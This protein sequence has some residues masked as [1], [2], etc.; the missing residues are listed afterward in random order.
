M[1]PAVGALLFPNT[2]GKQFLAADASSIKPSPEPERPAIDDTPVGTDGGD[3]DMPWRAVGVVAQLDP[4]PLADFILSVRFRA[5]APAKLSKRQLFARKYNQSE[6]RPIGWALA[7]KRFD[8]SIRPELFINDKSG[9]GEWYTFDTVAVEPGRWLQLFL[10]R[11]KD[12]ATG[13]MIKSE[14]DSQLRSLGGYDTSHI[15]LSD[16]PAELLLAP[17]LLDSPYFKGEIAEIALIRP[18]ELPKSDSKV[19]KLL[20][21]YST[22]PDETFTGAE[23]KVLMRKDQPLIVER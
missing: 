22:A 7:L 23:I 8:T 18:L 3:V 2:I 14:G 10:V 13:L 9:K 6:G 16:N 11:R 17:Q 4:N 21:E 20:L 19:A 12:G 5:T 15:D 1:A